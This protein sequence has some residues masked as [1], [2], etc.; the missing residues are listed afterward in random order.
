V[1]GPLS[2][3]AVEKVAAMVARS[4]GARR[5]GVTPT[6][7]VTGLTSECLMA[8]AWGAWGAG[9]VTATPTMARST[10]SAIGESFMRFSACL[11]TIP[12]K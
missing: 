5:R 2:A 7:T 8:R 6:A 11:A 9:L 1:Y 10:L 12:F 3:P 4:S